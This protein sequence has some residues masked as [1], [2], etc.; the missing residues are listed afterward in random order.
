MTRAFLYK[1]T[2]LFF[3]CRCGLPWMRRDVKEKYGFFTMMV[4]VFPVLGEKVPLVTG[5]IHIIRT[6]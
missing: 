1:N 5:T 4:I 3:Q 2:P 6:D